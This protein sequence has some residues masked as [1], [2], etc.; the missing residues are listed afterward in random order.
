MKPSMDRLRSGWIVSALFALALLGGCQKKTDDL[1]GYRKVEVAN[2]VTP[3]IVNPNFADG[4]TG[5]S[6]G[7]GYTAAPGQGFNQ[8]GA[9]MYERTDPEA[10][11]LATQTIALSPGVNYRFSAMIRCEGVEGAD[12]SGA[13]VAMEFYKNG[14]WITGVYPM[15]VKGT[16][17]WTQVEGMAIVP[18]DADSCQFLLYMRKGITGKAWFTKATVEPLNRSAEI[19]RAHV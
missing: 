17:D 6:V 14:K 16:S 19:G 15:G 13:S 2:I 12:A 11:A 8:T 10:Y 9:L 7:P 1:A 4:T 5:W 18:S 3:T